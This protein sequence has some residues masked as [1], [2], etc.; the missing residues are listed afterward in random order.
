M[1]SRNVIKEYVPEAYYHIYARG[2]S[3]Q[4]IF[5]DAADYT[6]FLSLFE[7][8]LSSEQKIS[9]TGE[10]YPHYKNRL[11]LYAYCLMS[12]HFH[13]MIYQKDGDAIEK[14][15]RSILTS[16]SRYFNIRHGRSGSLFES[17]YKAAHIDQ[18]VYLGH[19]TRY[20]HLNPRRWQNYRHSSLQY[21]INPKTAPE[22]LNTRRILSHFSSP[23]DYYAFHADYVEAKDVL[24]KIK[25]NLAD[26]SQRTL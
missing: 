19:I 2:N 23:E 25:H 10:P 11:V 7:R 5:V 26:S 3:K 8:Y 1:P 22:W 16:Y 20:I 4:K 9:K 15:M 13:M 17:R 6:Y 24:E 18:H 21:Y 12:N 14:L